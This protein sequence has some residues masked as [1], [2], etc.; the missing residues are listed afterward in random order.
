LGISGITWQTDPRGIPLGCTGLELSPR[1]MAKLGYLYL[2]RGQWN[3]A[4][5]VP[6]AWIEQSTTKHIE[7]KGLMNEAEDDGYGY[8]WWMDAYGGYSAH[9]FG[10][11][12]I[13]VVPRLNLVAVFTG[14][15]ADPDFPTPRKLMETFILPAV[16][17]AGPLPAS[18]ATGDLQEYVEQIK[19]PASQPVA[20]LPEIAK[21]ISGQTYQITDSPS[22]YIQAVTLTF[23]EE[24][25][26]YK[27]EA[28]W[29]D[30]KYNVKGGLDN[31]FYLNEASE[32]G[33]IIALKGYWHDDKT[34]VETV[35]DFLYIETVT[36]KYTFEGDKLIM[37]INSSM[38]YSFQMLGEMIETDETDA[39]AAASTRIA[40]IDGMVQVYVP[41]G[42]FS[43]G[44]TDAAAVAEC[45]RYQYDCMP[46]FFLDN[47]PPHTVALDAFWLDKTEVTN[48]MYA[49]C[50]EA[51]ACQPPAQTNSWTNAEY[52]GNPE[53]DNYPVIY[54]SWD[55][56]HT[57]CA[58]A[59]RRLPSEAEWEK[60]A[61]GTD[62]RQYPWGNEPVAGPRANFADKN[63][64]YSNNYPQEDDGYRDVAPV[65]SYP[66]G[67]SPYGALDMAGNVHEWVSSL[68]KSYPY[69]ADDG[70]EAVTA[71]GDR[72]TRGNACDS[73]AY[74]MR[75]G[76][77]SAMAPDFRADYL[78][79]RCAGSP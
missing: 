30:V 68:Y 26:L 76:Y 6:A 19:N 15:L 12:Y 20:P 4:Q 61:R 31:R 45:T 10:G 74:Q 47:E 50:V 75:A 17:S 59:G 55:D 29:L 2:N 33:H 39:A 73:A 71:P 72:A 69:Q 70:R 63:F 23:A 3:G 42:E 32:N 21:Q 52:F 18:P 57:Y 53:F 49:L 79:F 13:F 77:R 11:Q 35:K 44:D 9:G 46:G 48:G 43:M 14:G 51:G 41:A 28:T 66:A 8:F 27:S 64:P 22:P 5:I 16:K 67:A 38:G 24:P 56:A 60:A 25:G 40:E 1:D 78:G 58:W 7:T 37:D 65:G 34:F 36:Q 54:V 62:G